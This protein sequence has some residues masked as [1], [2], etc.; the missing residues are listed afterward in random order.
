MDRN[1]ITGILLIVAI[2]LTWSILF[3]PDE[4]E[5]NP[6]GQQQDSTRTE[7]IDPDRPQ[8]NNI[9]DSNPEVQTSVPR[10][11]TDS[12]WA[13]LTDSARQVVLS[14]IENKRYGSYSGVLEGTAEDITVST[15]RYDLVLN[16]QGGWFKSLQLKDYVTYDKKPLPIIREGD[17]N[18][19]NFL[20]RDRV[21]EELIQTK[22]IYFK[23]VNPQKTINVTGTGSSEY[24]LRAELGGGQSL[25]YVY[26]FYGDSYDLDFEVRFND[27]AKD[28]IKSSVE[29][30]WTGTIPLTEKA[31][32]NM[33]QKTTMYYMLSGDLDYLSA[34]SQTDE[35]KPETDLDWLAFKSQFFSMTLIPQEVNGFRPSLKQWNPVPPDP[36]DPYSGN[37]V[38]YMN[39]SGG[40]SLSGA[41]TDA[42][43]FKV[44]AGPLEYDLLESYEI[45][46][47]NQID[48]GWAI[49]RPINKYIIIPLFNWLE[50]FI[51]SYGLIILILAFLVKMF[52]YPLTFRSY[53]ST[54]KMRVINQTP[55][56][57]A[58]EE[59]YK[60]NATQL[61]QEKMKIY[62]R[63]GVNMFGGCLPMLLQYPFLISLFFFFPNAIELR[64]ESF[65]W[66]DD[67]STF[68]SVLELPF[69]IPMYGDHVSLFTLLMTISIFVYTLINQRMQGTTATNKFMKYFPYIMPIFF[70]G[71][72]NNYSAGLSWYYLLSNLISISQ[73][74]LTKAYINDEKIL[75]KMKA[76]AKKKA[77]SG[78][79]GR[80]EKWVA[81]Q[82]K[83]QAEA[84]KGSG[85]SGQGGRGGRRGNK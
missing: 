38:K 44:F 60:D 55:E 59:K 45:G 67:L 18:T 77:K 30:D 72:L 64:Q 9:A 8:P 14:E 37:V 56:V 21:A 1:T 43:K 2:V 46:M 79:K 83:K 42:I 68:D 51:G 76:T 22:D 54:A 5:K 57:K 61:Q 80:L 28:I 69:S 12:T 78:K 32:Y 27:I 81:N 26:T 47:E 3:G 65:L 23:P 24:I 73:T 35:D 49:F 29:L 82:Q 39:A 40:L 63:M 11:Y 71:F 58:L 85:K 74:T 10:G 36:E 33:R 15:G 41:S 4:E 7:Q 13:A 75:D 84:K 48:L 31:M 70:L 50:G 53:V 34:V 16:T 20:Y 52:L 19:L 66:A 25:E 6:K 17:V 62:R